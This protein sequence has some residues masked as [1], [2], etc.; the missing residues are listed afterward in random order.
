[1]IVYVVVTIILITTFAGISG[2]VPPLLTPVLV[3]IELVSLVF[4]LDTK[5]EI[6]KIIE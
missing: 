3:A 2:V 5:N 1:M 4:Y 6:G